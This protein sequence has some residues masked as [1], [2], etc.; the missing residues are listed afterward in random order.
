MYRLHFNCQGHNK[1]LLTINTDQQKC[2]HWAEMP[3]LSRNA[4]TE[5]KCCHWAEI[6]SPWQE[7]SMQSKENH[8]L[9]ISK[10]TTGVRYQQPIQRK[11]ALCYTLRILYSPITTHTHPHTHALVY[12]HCTYIHTTQQPSAHTCTYIYTCKHTYIYA[13]MGASMNG[14]V[15]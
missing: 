7:W 12:I 9:L 5:Q 2:R 3:S 4:V 11:N 14:G 13:Y 6:P 1:P 8:S 10:W 15:L